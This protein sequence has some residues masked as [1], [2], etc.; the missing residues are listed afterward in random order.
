MDL[1]GAKYLCSPEGQEALRAARD[2]RSIPLHRRAAALAG[3][4]SRQEIRWVLQA[5][6]LRQRAGARCP[7]AEALLFTREALEQASAW[8]VAV[9]RA[10]RWETPA[11]Q[12]LS[13]LG[14]GIGLDALATALSGRPVVAYEQDPVRARLLGF[15]AEALG[16][17]ERLEVRS[18]D[19]LRAAPHG[20]LGYLDP[21]RRQEGQRTRDPQA[22]RPALADWAP[23]LG[24]FERSMLKLPPRLPE[25]PCPGQPWE[26]VSLGGRARERRVFLG[27]FDRQPPRRALALPGGRQIEGSG[28]PWPEARAPVPGDWLLDPDVSVVLAGLVGD[29]ARRDDLTPLHPRIAYLFAPR[30]REQS[31]GHWMRVD[32]LLPV[33]ARSLD[34]WLSAR[35]IGQLT[36][37]KRGVQDSVRSW[38]RR[39]HPRGDGRGTLVFT[40]DLADRWV[41][42]ACLE[43]ACLEARES[44]TP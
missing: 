11:Q 4:S 3:R 31:P 1:A 28:C 14:A 9:E 43:E 35:G 5:D 34:A 42:Y 18:A 24:R 23:L 36:L 12:A 30:P 22:F 19:V 40:R 7:H 29:L 13:D 27:A 32:A 38:R 10:G 25:D 26:I 17:A 6:D 44:A 41:V 39:L 21:A 37:R 15:N 2:L 8:P 33:R 16:L 20:A